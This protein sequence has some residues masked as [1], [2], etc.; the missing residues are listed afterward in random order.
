MVGNT[1]SGE[2]ENNFIYHVHTAPVMNA[3][4]LGD[5]SATNWIKNSLCDRGKTINTYASIDA[6]DF[7]ERKKDSETAADH[8]QNA[9]N[10]AAWG[11]CIK[12][13]IESVFSS[14]STI[15]N[16]VF[17]DGVTIFSNIG[18][19]FDSSVQMDEDELIASGLNAVGDTLVSFCPTAASQAKDE[20]P[21]LTI[22]YSWVYK[23]PLYALVIFGIGAGLVTLGP[24]GIVACTIV[25]LIWWIIG[26]FGTKTSTDNTVWNIISWVGIFVITGFLYM[27]KTGKLKLDD[28]TTELRSAKT[29]MGE[30]LSENHLAILSFLVGVVVFLVWWKTRG[31]EDPSV[32]SVPVPPPGGATSSEG[33][34]TGDEATT[35]NEVRL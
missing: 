35:P 18:K 27:Y 28:L 34:E 1:F 17:T 9:L 24:L 3:F 7:F 10:P 22:N 32:A 12:D 33:G 6:R 23:A 5:T 8:I 14:S 25:A 15:C 26:F 4:G 13:S 31:S 19:Y 20:G 2:T 16:E 30:N 11:G 29:W 21:L